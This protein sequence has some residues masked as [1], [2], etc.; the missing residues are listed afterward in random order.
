MSSQVLVRFAIAA[1]RALL[2]AE[3]QSVA[4]PAKGIGKRAVKR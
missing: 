4:V 3:L 2:Q 1:I